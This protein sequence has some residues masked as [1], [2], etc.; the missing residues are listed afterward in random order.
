MNTS[1]ATQPNPTVSTAQTTAKEP[2]QIQASQCC[3]TAEQATCCAPDDKAAC[4]G[5]SPASTC[6][7]R[8]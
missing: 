4:C 7:C 2:E 6:G 3:S 8:G 1:G 5:T